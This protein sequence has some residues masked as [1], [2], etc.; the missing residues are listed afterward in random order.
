VGAGAGAG[1]GVG[2]GTGTGLGGGIGTS[3]WSLKLLTTT[4]LI[5]GDMPVILIVRRRVPFVRFMMYSS[6]LLV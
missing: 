4:P 5:S 2:V 1:A 3:Y 6:I